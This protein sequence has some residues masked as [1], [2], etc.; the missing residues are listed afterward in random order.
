MP[1]VLI[2]FFRVKQL[3][4][5]LT[6]SITLCL[7]NISI[8]FL[9]PVGLPE[10][11]NFSGNEIESFAEFLVEEVGEYDDFFKEY[12]DNESES[13]FQKTAGSFLCVLNSS[14]DLSYSSFCQAP[15]APDGH[16]LFQYSAFLNI[17]TPPPKM[18]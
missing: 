6:L 16:I 5:S 3:S 11:R 1:G 10:E 8:N 14:L 13:S 7:F 18:V 4:V 9:N 2:G 15:P 17:S 12:D